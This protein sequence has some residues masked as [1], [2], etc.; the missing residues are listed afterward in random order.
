MQEGTTFHPAMAFFLSG[1]SRGHMYQ[2]IL[3]WFLPIFFLLM[4]T[5]DVIQDYQTK[6]HHILINKVGRC[7]YIIEKLATSFVIAFI[8][9][10]I[11]LM[12]N[13]LFVYFLF[14]EGNFMKGLDKIDMKENQL[15]TFSIEH[16]Y[17]AILLFSIIACV[18][19]GLS[20]TLGASMSLLFK[21]K[22]YAYAASFFIWFAFVMSKFS[23]MYVFQ[24][25]TEIDYEELTAV[26][27]LTCVSLLLI[28]VIV[29]IYGVKFNED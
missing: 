24:P 14:K 15:F 10:A 20:G 11:S 2:I 16:P 23:V 25:F 13:F 22:K 3:F 6:Y 5:D 21:N 8:T 1:S 29:W 26:L 27:I 19:A 18:L 4:G 9:M 12:L 17:L 7:K 28:P